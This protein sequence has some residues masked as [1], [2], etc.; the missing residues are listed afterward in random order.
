MGS[1]NVVLVMVCL[2]ITFS[3]GRRL[4]QAQ[5]AAA[6]LML[7]AANAQEAEI[8][9]EQVLARRSLADTTVNVDTLVRMNAHS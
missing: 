6:E 7:Q 1:S 4:L 9:V 2:Q 5:D 3:S 8:G